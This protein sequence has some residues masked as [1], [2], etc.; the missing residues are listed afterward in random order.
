MSKK[1]ILVVEDDPNIAELVQ[2]NLEK[3]GYAAT[4]AVDGEQGLASA[5]KS[6]PDFVILDL[7]LPGID[8]IEVCQSMRREPALADLPIIM[9]TAR[10]SDTD[11]IVGLA[12]GADDY[13]PKPFSPSVLIARIKALD[14]RIK[15]RTG[16]RDVQVIGGL[17]IDKPAHKV[18]VNGQD[19]YLTQTEFRLL[20]AMADRPGRALSRSELLDLAIG[21]DVFVVDR[22]IDVHVASLR[23]KLGDCADLIETVRGLGYRFKQAV[24]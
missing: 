16:P 5:R 2:Y 14:R 7:M 8:G 10:A 23:R 6:R 13:I 22:T 20:A 24:E 11:V 19:V 21:E 12:V 15:T 1:T 3:N 9:L 17:S 4:I 18:F